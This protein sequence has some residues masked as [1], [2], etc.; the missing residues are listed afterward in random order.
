MKR[1]IGLSK[2]VCCRLLQILLLSVA[3]IRRKLLKMTHT[4][5]QSVHTNKKVAI[6]DS[7]RRKMNLIQI[8]QCIII[9][10]KNR[11]IQFPF[12][13]L[14][15]CVDFDLRDSKKIENIHKLNKII[16]HNKNIDIRKT[17]PNPIRETRVLKLV[18][19]T[20]PCLKFWAL[21]TQTN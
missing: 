8:L 11:I 7:D 6:F 20:I 10:P 16:S 5:E 18:L 4:E 14:Y 13:G 17:I 3:S 1:G 21:V 9:D 19:R 12:W 15:I 2:N